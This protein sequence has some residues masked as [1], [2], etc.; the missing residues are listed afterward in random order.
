MKRLNRY[1][2]LSLVC[3]ISGFVLS[4]L[5]FL[6]VLLPTYSL[7]GREDQSSTLTDLNRLQNLGNLFFAMILLFVGGFVAFMIVGLAQ[8]HRKNE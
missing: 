2:K 8:E 7:V 6:F 4:F 5:D 1:I 3:L